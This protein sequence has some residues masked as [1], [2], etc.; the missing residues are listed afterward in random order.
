MKTKQV[1]PTLYGG[2]TSPFAR[3]TKIYGEVL[4]ANFTYE[5]ID[6]YSAEFIDQFNPLRQIPTM[7]ADDM[8]IFDSRTIFEYFENSTGH[9]TNKTD[10]QQATR[11]SL[12]LG[13]TDAC[14]QYR[15]E[16]MLPEDERNVARISKL[17]ARMGRCVEQLEAWA[18]LITEGEIRLEHIVIACALE[19]LDFRYTSGWRR[20]CTALDAWVQVFSERTDMQQTRPV[21]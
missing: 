20:D 12:A 13:M 15:M 1:Q 8:A 17:K 6:I 18:D 2:P 10:F 11:I 9:K 4:G 5:Q 14:L 3:M 16:M 19:Y 7:V 21:G